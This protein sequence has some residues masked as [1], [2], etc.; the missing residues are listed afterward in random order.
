MEDRKM[1]EFLAWFCRQVN[2]HENFYIAG[3]TEKV[4]IEDNDMVGDPEISFEEVVRRY[5]K[6][7][8]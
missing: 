3:D 7:L 1:A 2:Y 4:W 5:N 8:E 6:T